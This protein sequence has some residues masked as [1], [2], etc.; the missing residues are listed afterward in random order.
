MMTVLSENASNTRSRREAQQTFFKRNTR[1]LLYV[2]LILLIGVLSVPIVRVANA[3]TGLVAAYSFDENGG[4]TAADASG[5]G[6]TATLFG[7][8]TWV[9]G[10]TSSGLNFDGSSGYSTAPS[11]PYLA[12]WTVSAWVQSSAAP[13]STNYSGP[14]H[15]DSNLQINWN[16]LNAAFRGAAALNVGGTWYAASFGSLSA[17][18]WY[19]LAATYDGETLN[20]YTNGVLVSSNTAPSGP[21]SSDPNPLTFGKHA[22]SS[23]YF[24]GNIDDVRVYNRALSQ[25]EIQTDMNTPVSG[26]GSGGGGSLFAS[27]VSLPAGT[28]THGVTMIDL[29]GDGKRDLV[30]A[31]AAT[32]SASVWLGNGDATFGSRTDFATGLTP[33]MV[34]VGDLNRDGK[35]DL[36]TPNQDAASVSVLLG[37]GSGGFGGHVDYAACTGTHEVAVGDLNGDG[38]PDVIA[39]CWGGSVVSVLLGNGNGTL[40]PKVDYASGYAPH[41]VVLGRFDGDA[42]LDAAIANHGDNT[43][44]ILRGNGNGTFQTPVTYGVGSGPH[45]IRAGDLNGDGRLDLVT[46]N[47]FSNN[48]SVLLGNGDGTF[49]AAANYPTGLGPKGIAIADVSGD[50]RADVITANAAGSYPVCCNPGGNLLSVLLG[51]GSGSLGAPTNYTVGQTPFAIATGDLD[52]D[53]D[54]DVATANWDSNDVTV[55]KNLTVNGGGGGDTTPPTITITTPTSNPTYTTGTSPLTLGGT[56]SDNVGVTQVT[57]SNSAG[58]SGTASGTTSWTVSGIVLQPGTNVLTV[59][60]R[61]AANNIGTDTLTVTYTTTTSGLMASYAFVENGGSTAADSS[62]NGNTATLFGG[63]TWVS[64]HTGSGLSFDGSTGYSTA[65]SVPYVA[66]W[67][68]SA[69]VRSPAAPGASGYSGPV[70]REKNFQINWNHVD[71]AFRGAAALNVGGTW[72]AASFGPLAANTWYFLAATYDGETL[73]AYTNGVLVTSNTAP[74]GPASSDANPLTFGKHAAAS[75]FFQGNIDDVRVYN[76]ALSTA[77]IQTDMNTPVGGGGGGDT[78]PPSITITSPT[79]NPTYASSTSPL[80]LGGTASDNVG[81]TQVTWSNSAGG[82]GIASGTTSWTVSSIVLQPGTN[83]LTVT[84]SDAANNIGTD[85]LTVTYTPSVSGLMA[86]YNFDEGS[87][88][89]AAD[90]SGNGNTATLFGGAT[91]VTGHSGNGLSFDGGSGYSTAPSVPYV[92]NWTISAWVRSPAAPGA[93]GYAGPVHRE[94]NFQINWNHA[95]PNFRGAAAVNV[96]GTWYAASFGTL[97]ANTWY[98]L[99]ATYDGETLNAYSNGALVTSNAAPSGP[100]SSD[101]N[102]LTFGKHAANSYFF[103]GSIDDVRVYNRALSLSEIQSDMNSPVTG[104]GPNNPSIVGQWAAPFSLPAKD[105]HNV[106]MRTGGVLFWD[107]FSFGQQAYVWNPDGT[108]TYVPTTDN[109]F[110]AGLTSLADGNAFLVGGHLSVGVGTTD[111]NRFD[112]VTKTWTTVNPMAYQRWYPTATSLPDGRVLVVSG[113]MTSINDPATIPEVYNPSTNTWTQLT[114]AQMTMPLYPHMFVL[115]DGR[116]LYAS[117]TEA[118]VQTQVLNV[119]TQTWTM[120]DPVAVNGGSSAMYRPGK[121]LKSG[122]PGAPNRIPVAPSAST[123]YVLDMTQGSPS[124]RSVQ[125][126]AFPRTFHTLTLLPDGNVLATGGSQTNDPGSQPVYA[127]EIWNAQSETWTTMATM[128]MGRTYHETALLMPDGRVYVAGGGGCCNAPDQFN[129]EIFSPPYLFKGARPVITSVASNVSYGT[130]SFLATPDAASIQ[131]VAFMRLGAQTHQFDMSQ[132]YVPLSFTQT[133]GGLNVTWPANANLAP[134]G[135]Y[136]VFIVNGNGVPSVASIVNIH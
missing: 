95:D 136:F 119:A 89:I 101:P 114:S 65:P 38:S 37:N 125:P 23:Q 97:A 13:S 88:S 98:F 72:Y 128:Q 75:Y 113:S 58:G 102:P 39:A 90:A 32:N 85:T 33:K 68:V 30:A 91:W 81:V 1:A 127:A 60:A 18:T 112:P 47:E 16:H 55:L 5:N 105:V 92:A 29:N 35:L 31:N 43:I 84:A 63:T 74:S 126:M 51:S 111:A 103:Q 67:T 100:A 116:V 52:G 117:S 50:G 6:N 66:N 135:D 46:A 4:S 34:A 78:T 64:G 110:C 2:A 26:G 54:V 77:E 42:N 17:N 21:A 71:P 87:G 76:R 41:S 115:P 121:I 96:G 124:W 132:R 131:S 106:I 118:A 61:D 15:R 62:G 49:Q 11:V 79:S 73:N 109:N 48:V 20:A 99:A 9:T 22:G 36:V 70:H 133:S 10:H 57:W 123:A 120:V 59:S 14:I 3:A 86:A 7:G 80:A 27:A 104:S 25:S 83:V 134:P 8:A 107:A 40:Q 53:G 24:Q 82:S 122:S 93:S 129:A 56:A 108:F 45:S 44:S 69:W 19:F 94:K 28:Q 12:N 130:Q